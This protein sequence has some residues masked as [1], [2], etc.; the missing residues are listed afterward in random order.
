MPGGREEDGARRSAGRPPGRAPP[1]AGPAQ[2]APGPLGPLPVSQREPPPGRRPLQLDQ[3]E[4]RRENAEGGERK[5]RPG[6]EGAERPHGGAAPHLPAA[7]PAAHLALRA[8]VASNGCRLPP[9]HRQRCPR[10]ANG[11]GRSGKLKGRGGTRPLRMRSAPLAARRHTSH[12]S[13]R[14]AARMRHRAT[15]PP[16]PRA[17][18]PRPCPPGDQWE[19]RKAVTGR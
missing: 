5:G 19:L 3:P 18:E 17:T 1:P 11:C 9:R 15:L 13:G 10:A 12:R 6:R 2:E 7:S 16:P 4:L 14:T 8:A